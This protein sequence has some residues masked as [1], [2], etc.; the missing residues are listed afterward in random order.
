MTDNHPVVSIIVVNLNGKHLLEDCFASLH[1]S[2]YPR[3]RF[4]VVLV[5]NASTDGSVEYTKEKFPW[6]RILQLD[7]N[8]GFCKPNNEG[9]KISRGEYV[10][11]L[12]NDTVVTPQWLPELVKGTQKE[13][14]IISCASKMLLYDRKDVINT[15]GG[16]ITIIG[17]VFYKGWGDKD[18]PKYDQFEYTG[19]GCGAG[20]LVKKEFFESIGGFDEDQFIS[21]DETELGL[22]AWLYGYKVLYVPTAVM[23]HK[24]SGTYGSKGGYQPLKIYYYRRNAMGNI[25]K[26]LEARNA[27]KGL[28]VG[29]VFDLYRCIKY[30]RIRNFGGITATAKAYLFFVKNL[31]KLLRKRKTGQKRRVRSDKQLYELGVLATLRECI[32]EE[33]RLSKL[34]REE[35]YKV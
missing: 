33:R 22:K 10:V 17:G 2:E 11:I 9:V 23:Y 16:K 21:G 13:E 30:V 19:F 18:G 24:L 12:N 8:Y 35:Y 27:F 28:F 4:E 25:V 31:R 32:V 6:V 3:E 26:N 7:K 5:D 14:Q 1:N 29:L 20:V 15:A 34:E